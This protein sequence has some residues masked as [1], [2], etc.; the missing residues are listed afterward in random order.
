MTLTARFTHNLYHIPMGTCVVVNLTLDEAKDLVAQ[1]NDS[2]ALRD[3]WVKNRF[4]PT[5]SCGMLL[6][7]T[8]G[9]L[10]AVVKGL[11]AFE[12]EGPRGEVHP[13]LAP[14][15][16]ALDETRHYEIDEADR[17][18]IESIMG[19][20]LF[21]ARQAHHLC[22]ITPSYWLVHLYDQV[23][24]TADALEHLPQD[25]QDRIYEQYEYEGGDD[26]YVHCHEIDHLA[27]TP[28]GAF[29]FVRC[30]DQPIQTE[31]DELFEA[32]R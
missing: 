11:E 29:R 28:P 13:P 20:Y 10:E 14:C 17:P 9:D 7:V 12:A 4:T 1:G 8:Y 23:R 5:V 32:I 22:E 16:V 18:H 6:E 31:Y 21:D 15:V 25:E 27:D 2:E 3:L 30:D 26:L 24:L 19:V